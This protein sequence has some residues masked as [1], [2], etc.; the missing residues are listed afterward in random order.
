MARTHPHTTRFPLLLWMAIVVV[1]LKQRTTPSHF[2]RS[3]M[4]AEIRKT[5]GDYEQWFACTQTAT[6]DHPREGF[7]DRVSEISRRAIAVA[8][9]CGIELWYALLSSCRTRSADH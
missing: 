3:T 7:L 1:S 8:A 2:I 5:H 6:E 4:D 9:G